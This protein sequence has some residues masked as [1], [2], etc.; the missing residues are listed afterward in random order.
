MRLAYRWQDELK[1]PGLK[2]D[3]LTMEIVADF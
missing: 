3:G 2:G 1:G